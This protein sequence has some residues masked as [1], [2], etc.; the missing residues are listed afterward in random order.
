[1][2]YKF[3]IIWVRD[4]NFQKMN[5]EHNT[6]HKDGKEIVNIILKDYLK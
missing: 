4:V 6:E 5:N 3:V 2:N 1:M